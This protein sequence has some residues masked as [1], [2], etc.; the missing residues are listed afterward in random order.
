MKKSWRVAAI[1][2]GAAITSAAGITQAATY[3]NDFSA[4]LN[5]ITLT[6]NVLGPGEPNPGADVEGGTLRLTQA[7]NSQQN[8]AFLPDLDVGQAI[9]SFRASFDYSI[10]AGTCCG[11]T[12]SERPRR[13]V[14]LRLRPH[15]LRYL[16]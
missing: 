16:R 10:A 1:T 11:P 13:R 5:G 2:A 4:G 12:P 7:V 8:S 15:D 9:Q 3:N 6:Q 14:L